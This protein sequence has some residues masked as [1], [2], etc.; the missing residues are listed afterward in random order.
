MTDQTKSSAER[1]RSP[2]RV[3]IVGAGKMALNHAR[4]IAH[5]GVPA[6]VVGVADPSE[7]ARKALA[8]ALPGT[9]T[10]DSLAALIENGRPD[11]LHIVTPPASHVSLARQA[12]EA[13]LHAYVEKPFAPTARE[14]TEL[15]SLARERGVLLCPGHQ[16]LYDPPTVAIR[17]HLPAIGRVVHV[18][19]YFSFRTVRRMPGGRAPARADHQLLDILPHPVYLL[20]DVLERTGDGP[21]EVV[22]LRADVPG[23]VHALVRQGQV[24]G[25]LVVTLDGRPIESTL[26][27]V[28][29][30]GSVFGDY[31]RSVVFRDLGPGTSGIDKLLAP[32]RR[33]RQQFFG[34]TA[35]LFRR[36]VTGRK[37]YPGLADL[38]GT[39]YHA[40]REGGDPPV[41]DSSVQETVRLCE[42][43]AASMADADA[44][45]V[46]G[47]VAAETAGPGVLVTGGTGFLGRELVRALVARG[48]AV[49]V[50]A[51][52]EPASWERLPGAAYVTGDLGAEG[53]K[54]WLDGVDA[55]IHCAAETAGGWEDHQRNSIDATEYLMRA[56]A[57]AGTRRL[58]HV[59]S[60]AVMARSRRPITDHDPLEP[61]SRGQGP[62]VWGKLESERLAVRLGEEFGLDVKVVRPGALVDM[63]DLEPP[64]RLGK[65]LGNL[66]VAVGSP[67]HTLGVTDVAFA[68]EILAE[69]V[70]A[71]DSLPT[72]LN[73]LDPELPTKRT[74]VQALKAQNPDLR[75]IWLPTVLLVP[76]SWAAIVLQKVLRP[77]RP[78]INAAKV[79]AF[80]A[81]DTSGIRRLAGGSD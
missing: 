66:F 53:R 64:G 75:V 12:I 40:V 18:E 19:S 25:S 10:W 35:A 9:R 79:F 59:S 24:T 67:R 71:W 33:V 58:I 22:A 60:N 52:R 3:G 51:R 36:F 61:D 1:D 62:Y 69:A 28:G 4:A 77:G 80:Q 29:T 42:T 55:V 38:F 78:A 68:G 56:M 31:V 39:F 26:R 34:T 43:I 57:A 70:D 5:A 6:T 65:R 81:W 11:V 14:A 46:A 7:P 23:T 47:L 30:R 44:Q 54:E 20:L 8:E 21:L 16:L 50:L 49:R 2:I 73:L 32:Y 27:V 15:L 37:S 45:R 17:R 48:R 72:P 63:R 76:L 13:G 41:S 74:L